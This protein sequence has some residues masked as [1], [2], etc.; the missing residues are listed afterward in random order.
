MAVYASSLSAGVSG[1]GSGSAVFAA[2]FG[3]RFG[4]AF[5]AAGLAGASAVSVARLQKRQPCRTGLH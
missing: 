4:E 2:C 1:V 5:F 3:A